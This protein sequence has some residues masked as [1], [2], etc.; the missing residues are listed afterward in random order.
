MSLPLL[1]NA[2]LLPAAAALNALLALD[3]LSERRLAPW[4][5]RTLAIRCREPSLCLYIGVHAGKLSVSAISGAVPDATLEGSA[6]DLIKLLAKGG[7]THSLYGSGVTLQGSAALV[8]GL[9]E[10][11]TQLDC[12]WEY[13]L[14]RFTGDL[15]AAA[16]G[17]AARGA[18]AALDHSGMRLRED[19]AGYLTQESGLTPARGEVAAFYQGLRE[20]EL[21]L[22]R[23]QARLTLLETAPSGMDQPLGSNP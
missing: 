8:S 17:Q 22:D 7:D 15:P 16:F 3:P 21:R 1:Q 14:S 20:F 11:L 9:R 10:A 5:G 13:Q 6:R 18:S 12:D 23:L 2:L 19:L 4:R